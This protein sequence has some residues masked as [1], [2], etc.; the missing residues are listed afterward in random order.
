MNQHGK[1]PHLPPS[2]P[3]TRPKGSRNRLG[4]AFVQALQDDFQEHGP[5]VIETIRSEKPEHYLKLVA[6][7]LP[8]ELKVTTDIELSDE[9]L[10]QRIRQ[11]AAALDLPLGSEARAGAAAGGEAA[12]PG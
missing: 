11:L 8:N 7:L 6:S 1:S 10:D 2:P 12:P 9:Q 4:Q 5:Q 3:T